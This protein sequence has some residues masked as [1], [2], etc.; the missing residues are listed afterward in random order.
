MENIF[1]YVAFLRGI[2]VGGNTAIKMADLKAAFEKIGFRDVRTVLAS[3]NVIFST[4]SKDPK[5]LAKEIE[6]G[7]KKTFGKD[8]GVIVRSSDDLKKLQ[9]SDPFKG[10]KVTPSTRLYVTFLS[11]KPR[12]RTIGIPYST[13]EGEFR[14]LQATCGEVFRVVDLLKGKGTPEAMLIL[15]REFGSRL[16]TRNWNT[17]LKVLM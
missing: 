8:I 7:L 11:E 4:I 10:I 17:V 1:C 6:T 12:P 5:M 2:N 13:P 15:E 9:S 3:G 16:T 14:I